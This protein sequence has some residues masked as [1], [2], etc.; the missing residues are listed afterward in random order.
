VVESAPSLVEQ[1]LQRERQVV[2]AAFVLV[3]ALAWVYTLA[4]VGME[5]NAFEMTHSATAPVMTGK[6]TT[7]TSMSMPKWNAGY[8]V[9]MLTMWWVMMVG[10]MLPSAAPVAVLQCRR[11]RGSVGARERRPAFR[12]YAK[13][14]RSLERCAV[15]RGG[16]VATHPN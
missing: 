9:I 2:L 3:A 7:S 13:H 6:L 1:I 8:A 12:R 14:K 10:M 5:M 16:S 15:T 11:G 4:G